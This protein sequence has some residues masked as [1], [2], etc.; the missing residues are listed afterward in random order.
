[1]EKRKL[2]FIRCLWHDGVDFIMFLV[3]IGLFAYSQITGT[4]VSPF[5]AVLILYVYFAT[6]RRFILWQ[7]RRIFIDVLESI[8]EDPAEIIANHDDV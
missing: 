2:R 3:I 7:E 5:L 4:N 6:Y 8:V 1:M